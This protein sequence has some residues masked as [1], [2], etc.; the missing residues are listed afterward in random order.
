MTNDRQADCRRHTRH[1][2]WKAKNTRASAPCAPC[3]QR[4]NRRLQRRRTD[5]SRTG[6]E[7]KHQKQLV[8]TLA[9]HGGRHP[10]GSTEV[11]IAPCATPR[12][13]PTDVHDTRAD[14]A[15]L[16][17][18]LRVRPRRQHDCRHRRRYNRNCRNIARRYREQQ[19]YTD[20]R[21][22]HRRH[23]HHMRR[24]HNIKVGVTHSRTHQDAR[25]FGFTELENPPEDYVVHGPNLMTALPSECPVSLSG[26]MPLHRKD[27][28]KIEAAVLSALEAAT[29]PE[30][31]A[32][33]VRNG[34]YL[35]GVAY[36]SAVL[37]SALSTRRYSIP[38]SRGSPSCCCCHAV[39]VWH[40]RT[41]NKFKFLIR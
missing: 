8:L 41:S 33:I 30:L 29:P 21:T 28:L 34:I 20:C 40:L 38:H 12:S 3:T 39:Q 31:Y 2:R 17:I 23:S 37:T 26:N 32:D 1:S 11:E 24:A 25:R 16:G 13:T 9:A 27:N 19:E 6:K 15:A 10:S 36:C 35:A 7:G 5:D 22:T 4:R 14:G 18:G